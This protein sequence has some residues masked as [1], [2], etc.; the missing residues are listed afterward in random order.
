MID[1]P[2]GRSLSAE[3]LEVLRKIAVRA[4]FELGHKKSEVARLLGVSEK[5]VGQWCAAYQEEGL[6]GLQGQPLG[7]PLG[8]GRVLTPTQEI[9]V[10]AILLDASPG[11]YDIPSSTWTRQAVVE[12]VKGRYHIEL[13]PQAMGIYLRR[14]NMTPQKPARQAREQDPEE[15]QEFLEKTLPDALERADREGGQLH[16]ADETGARVGDQIGTSYA[17]QGQTPVLEI[18]KTRIQ[19]NLISSVTPEG[20]MFHWLFPNTMDSEKFLEFLELL[21]SWSEEKLFLFLDRH[22]AH[23]AEAVEDWVA[24]RPDQIEI[25]WFPRYSPEHNPDEFLNNDL[26]QTLQNEPMPED[27]SEFRE[28]I[29]D[30]LESIASFPERVK[31]YFRQSELNF[32]WE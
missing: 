4:V 2:D 10:Q 8:V 13:T 29:R 22:P 7:R 24:E 3:T 27:T 12:L 25:I 15:V 16:F 14:W 28:R 23:T 1:L 26:K 11:D 17:P 9:I 18:P 30:I 31:G 21:V 6:S 5:A 32:A 20:E 19:Q